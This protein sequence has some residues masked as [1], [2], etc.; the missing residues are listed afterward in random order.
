MTCTVVR[1]PKA[2]RRAAGGSATRERSPVDAAAGVVGVLVTWYDPEAGLPLHPRVAAGYCAA[3]VFD[4]PA[5]DAD[6]DKRRRSIAGIPDELSTTAAMEGS[7]KRT[8]MSLPSLLCRWVCYHVAVAGGMTPS[9]RSKL[10]ASKLVH[11]SVGY[12]L[13]SGRRRSAAKASAPDG[14]H[15]PGRLQEAWIVDAM[16]GQLGRQTTVPA[17]RQVVV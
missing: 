1:T 7:R 13:R 6:A 10:R 14:R 16:A 8:A 2:D 11:V 12:R 3:H 9:C 15:R 5:H 4:E 17:F